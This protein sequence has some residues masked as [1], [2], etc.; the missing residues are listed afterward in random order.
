MRFRRAYSLVMSYYDQ[1][2]G[3][4]NFLAKTRF[5]C[6]AEC[7]D[8]L[9]KLDDWRTAEEIAGYFGDVDVDSLSEQIHEL[10][11]MDAIVVEGS[12]PA[13]VDDVFRKS[14]QWGMAGGY[15][16]F[17][18]R[19][20]EFPRDYTARDLLQRRKEWHQ[21]E[22]AYYAEYP[23]DQ[24]LISLPST[25]LRDEVFSLMHRRR[26]ETRYV[27][28]GIPLKSLA[29]CL[30]AGNGIVGFR[31][32][33]KGSRKPITMTPSADACNPYELY[34]YAGRVNGLPKGFYHYAS[35][36][37]ALVLKNDDEVK[38]ADLF[39][40]QDWVADAAAVIFLVAHFPRTMWTFHKPIGYRMVSMEAGFIGQNISLAATHLGLSGVPLGSLLHSRIERHLD[41]ADIEASVMLGM[42][43]GRPAAQ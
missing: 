35:A 2:I 27:A 26:S 29:D 28:E 3:L 9:A 1:Q 11:R 22:P 21:T 12:E 40:G 32:G 42:S 13:A 39:G 4:H 18:T 36:Q 17:I 7:L 15:F 23:A 19:D 43:I 37:H 38:I 10:V 16:H 30:Y 41:L 5:S 20:A 6:S 14:W 25:N 33:D 34:V 24:P 8:L 31:E